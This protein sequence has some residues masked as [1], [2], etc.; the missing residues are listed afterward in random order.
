MSIK[1][2]KEKKIKHFTTKKNVIFFKL[3]TYSIKIWKISYQV[4][5]Q[6]KNVDKSADAAW[7]L[8][9]TI[10]NFTGFNFAVL[11]MSAVEF[12]K[13]ENFYVNSA[14]IIKYTVYLNW[15]SLFIQWCDVDQRTVFF[16]DGILVCNFHR[17]VDNIAGIF[18]FP[19]HRALLCSNNNQAH[20]CYVNTVYTITV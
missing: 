5:N 7:Y 6:T 17:V 12:Q 20:C 1:F 19:S 13:K 16:F 2:K 18:A 14:N 4:H 9:V 10:R 3:N 15:N 11:S 8:L